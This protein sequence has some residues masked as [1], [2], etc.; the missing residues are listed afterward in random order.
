MSRG[1]P[2][3]RSHEP[4]MATGSLVAAPYRK[5]RAPLWVRSTFNFLFYFADISYVA[6]AGRLAAPIAC[7]LCMVCAQRLQDRK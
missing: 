4:K 2:C 1:G 5:V 7:S 6:T 3:S